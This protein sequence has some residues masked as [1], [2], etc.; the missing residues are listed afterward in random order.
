MPLVEIERGT[1]KDDPVAVVDGL[2]AE[3]GVGVALVDG[4]ITIFD[5]IEF[6]PEFR[7]IDVISEIAFLVMDLLDRELP[8]LAWR[9]PPR[10]ACLPQHPMGSLRSACA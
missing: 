5:C 9:C 2:D 7:W 1:D 8:V 6:N 3:G 4:A 10:P